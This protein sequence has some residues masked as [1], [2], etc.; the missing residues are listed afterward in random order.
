VTE[1]IWLQEIYEYRKT[2][3]M[4]STDAD[5]VNLFGELVSLTH[6]GSSYL[7]MRMQT[8]NKPVLLLAKLQ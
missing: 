6:G 1:A 7:S 3:T 4:K 8:L 5:I 2:K